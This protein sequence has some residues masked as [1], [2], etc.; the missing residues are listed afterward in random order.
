MFPHPDAVTETIEDALEHK[1]AS[2][3]KSEYGY[4]RNW[5][6]RTSRESREHLARLATEKARQERARTPYGGAVTEPTLKFTN[7]RDIVGRAS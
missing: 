3:W 6:R 4:L 1:A 2:K 7:I 5:L